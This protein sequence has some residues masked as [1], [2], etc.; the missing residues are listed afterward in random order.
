MADQ[1]PDE[2]GNVD[3]DAV[4]DAGDDYLQHNNYLK[5]QVDELTTVLDTSVEDIKE[6]VND[7]GSSNEMFEIR[8]IPH[9]IEEIALGNRYNYNKNTMFTEFFNKLDVIRKGDEW[10]ARV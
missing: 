4:H 7:M 1:Y 2:D 3:W 8:N 6:Y 9:I 10:Q 5:E